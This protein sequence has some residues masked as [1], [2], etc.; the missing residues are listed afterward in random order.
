MD[1]Q[2]CLLKEKSITKHAIIFTNYWKFI[3][4]QF[5]VKI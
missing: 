1:L 5:G 4:V 3:Y 2:I